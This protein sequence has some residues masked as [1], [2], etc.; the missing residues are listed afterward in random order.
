MADSPPRTTRSPDIE[1]LHTNP[2]EA[3]SSSTVP[4]PPSP[5]RDETKLIAE[6]QDLLA[7]FPQR[8]SHKEERQAHLR[9]LAEELRLQC[10]ICLDP[11]TNPKSTACLHTFCSAC[12]T[13]WLAE[14]A[15]C[16]YCRSA[17]RQR[18]PQDTTAPEPA[19]APPRIE[20]AFGGYATM[21][22]RIAHLRATNPTRQPIQPPLSLH[23]Q[24]VGRRN[25]ISWIPSEAMDFPAD[26]NHFYR[27]GDDEDD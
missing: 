25:A 12:L 11:I 5:E 8:H 3:S 9:K 1:A 6:L 13:T 4:S 27:S 17:V 14:H 2:R 21:L 20:P 16:P 26:Y 18:L 24:V 15:S 19:A 7:Q 22:D 23:G 10:S